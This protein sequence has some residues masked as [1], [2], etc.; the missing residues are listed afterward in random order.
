MLNGFRP[1]LHRPERIYKGVSDRWKGGRGLNKQKKVQVVSELNERFGRAKGV[2]L[3]DYKGLTVKEI[4]ELRRNLRGADLEFKVVKNTLA[5]RAAEGTPIE[6]ANDLFTGTI[7]VAIGY[8]DPVL[9]AKK[10][11]EFSK[12]N[13]KLKIKGGVI[14]GGLCGPEDVKTISELPARGTLLSMLVGAM[15]APMSRLASLLNATVARFIYAMNA[16]KQQ[17]ERI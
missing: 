14:E 15:Q 16:L 3:T 13:E 2:I 8:D 7:G 1:S 6:R 9:L 10:V 5:K 11:V 12:L 17:R 4:S